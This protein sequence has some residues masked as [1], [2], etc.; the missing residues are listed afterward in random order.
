MSK[1]SLT[2]KELEKKVEQYELAAKRALAD[3]ANLEKRVEVE[4]A[5]LVKLAAGVIIV[6]L[7]PVLDNLKKAA[8]HISD[9]GLAMVVDQFNQVLKSER[10]EEI[11]A[12][13]E[14]FDPDLHEAVEVVEGKPEDEG[15][16]IEVFEDG[17]AL[18]GRT[19]RPAKVKVIKTK[20]GE[21]EE[22][23]KKGSQF[24]DYA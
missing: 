18:D 5:N 2:K 24:G 8:I 16:I 22:K 19:I 3:Y 15:K 20:V 12:L 21:A 6:K 13:G 7:L 17:F 23:A 14:K 4:R 9:S 1:R 11:K 10:I